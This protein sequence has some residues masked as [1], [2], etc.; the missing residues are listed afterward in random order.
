[1]L[2]QVFQNRVALLQPSMPSILNSFT[3]Q[4]IDDGFIFL[5]ARLGGSRRAEKTPGNENGKDMG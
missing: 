1:M 2:E 3:P 4:G 5:G